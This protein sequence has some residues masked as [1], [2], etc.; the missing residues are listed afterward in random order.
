VGLGCFSPV[1]RLDERSEAS[2]LERSVDLIGSAL[3]DCKTQI[4]TLKNAL[5][6]KDDAARSLASTAKQLK[7]AL[8]HKSAEYEKEIADL[9]EKLK[10]SRPIETIDL[11]NPGNENVHTLHKTKS[12]LA[13][14]LEHMT[15]VVKVKVEANERANRA[16]EKTAAA[17]RQKEVALVKLECPICLEVKEESYAM[18]PCG[19][20][21][22]VECSNSC[23]GSSCPTCRGNVEHR[24]KLHK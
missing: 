23:A 2:Y 16:E 6:E 9:K 12:C 20:M 3:V 10:H 4:T 18:V 24:L 1:Q 5:A 22:C 11:T 7:E 19:H 21:M 15:A 17:E 8:D 13:R 14:Q